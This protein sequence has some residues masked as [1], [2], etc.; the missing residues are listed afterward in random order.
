MISSNNKYKY[1]FKLSLIPRAS[2]MLI[3]NDLVLKLI[4]LRL[5][6]FI[7]IDFGLISAVN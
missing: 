6:D 1:L 2:N 3:V 7:T 4:K 5:C